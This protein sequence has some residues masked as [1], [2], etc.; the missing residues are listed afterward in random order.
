MIGCVDEESKLAQRKGTRR[1]KVEP[2]GPECV[3]MGG[4]LQTHIFQ[5]IW[6][7]L[8]VVFRPRKTFDVNSGIRWKKNIE[9]LQ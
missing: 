2:I 1:K 9:A 8:V 5:S 7:S 6:E 3:D 4:T